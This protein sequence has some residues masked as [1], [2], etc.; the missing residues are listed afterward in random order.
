[1]EKFG[2]FPAWKSMGKTCF[3]LLVCKKK[4]IF[5]TFH[6]RLRNISSFHMRFRNISFKIDKFTFIV[7]AIVVLVF[8][9]GMSFKK[10]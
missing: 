4:I 10:D 6:M 3:G 8:D 9:L 1:M 2:H 5:Q 7:L